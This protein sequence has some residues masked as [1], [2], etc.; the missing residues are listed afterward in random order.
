MVKAREILLLCREIWRPGVDHQEV[1]C[2]GPYKA[3]QGARR[4]NNNNFGI[5]QGLVG[6]PV[7]VSHHDKMRYVRRERENKK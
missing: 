3:R 6:E 7:L 2:G 4:G 5:G 1:A